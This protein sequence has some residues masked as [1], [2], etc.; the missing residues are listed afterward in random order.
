MFVK[1]VLAIPVQQF[2]LYSVP[3]AEQDRVQAGKRVKVN[4][5]NRLTLGFVIEVLKDVKAPLREIKPILAVVDETP[6]LNEPLL[7]L[8]KWM[9]E[10]Y[11]A[12]LGEVLKLITPS[13]VKAREYLFPSGEAVRG[14]V[15][16]TPEQ[17]SVFSQLSELKLPAFSLI[18]GVTGSGKT[19]IYLSL[20]EHFIKKKS[21]LSISSLK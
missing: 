5:H 19:E 2:Y 13:A 18:Y 4:F 17:Q 7:S 10:Y 3:A 1:V 9:S 15:R 12:S 21:R 14:P 6:L 16:L 20:I 8:A 11:F